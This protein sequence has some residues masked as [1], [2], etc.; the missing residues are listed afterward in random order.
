MELQ[1][2]GGSVGFTGDVLAQVLAFLVV[3]SVTVIQV[4]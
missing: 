4:D 1:T 3:V 2:Q